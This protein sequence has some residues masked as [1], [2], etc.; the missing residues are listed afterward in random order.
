M[1]YLLTGSFILVFFI[2]T[3]AQ[4]V[5]TAKV[6]G[7][8]TDSVTHKPLGLVSVSV[9]NM[10]THSAVKSTVTSDKGTFILSVPVNTS[11]GYQLQV[12]HVGYDTKMITIDI[13]KPMLDLGTVLLNASAGQ[14]K[15][16]TVTASRPIVKQEIDRLTYDVQADPQAKGQTAMDMLRRVPL[17]TVDGDDN[18]ELQGSGS[19]RIFINGK[20]SA[21]VTNNPKD[22]LRAMP[23]SNIQRIEVIT[24]PPA[25]YDAEGLAGII[26]IIT[27]KKTA[28]GYNGTLSVRESLPFGPGL[29]FSGSAKQNKL[30]ISLFGGA[31]LRPH[32]TT[33]Q[34]NDRKTYGATPDELSQSAQSTGNG[35]FFYTGT[36]I[37][38][39]FDSLHLLSGYV[40]YAAGNS[41]Q[42]YNRS[43]SYYLVNNGAVLQSYQLLNNGGS[44]FRNLDLGLNYQIGFKHLKDELLTTSY[45][46]SYSLNGQFSDITAMQRFKFDQPDNNQ[47]DD[48]GYKEHTFQLDYVHP[49]KKL[50]IEAGAKAILRDNYS[51][52][53][54]EVY[55]SPAAGYVNDPTRSNNFNYKQDIY[56]IYNSYLLR[57]TKF[58][59]QAGVRAEFTQ[60]NANFTSTAT[61]LDMHYTNIIPTLSILRTF[62][63]NNSLT[64]GITNRLMRPGIYQL[65]PFVDRTNPQLIS[66]GNPNLHPVV[67]HL[68]E[69]SYNKVGKSSLNIRLSYMYTNNSIESVTKVIADTLSET[70]YDNVGQSKIARININ[71][72]FPLTPKWS[73][74]FNTGVFYVWIHGT[75]NG[76]FYSN[77]GPRTNTFV[78]TSYKLNSMW[79]FGVSAGYNRRYIT[80][81]GSSNDYY[82]TTFSTT[83]TLKK[84]T[85]NF[86]L[87]NPFMRYYAFTQYSDT[88]DFYQSNTS[89]G[90]YRNFTIGA[91]YK[92]GKLNSAIKKNKRGINNDDIQSSSN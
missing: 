62:K 68:F 22:V 84:F 86:N 87:N 21:L 91:S 4:G 66:T 52:S 79:Q 29:N 15:D 25:K 44:V 80:L 31:S 64:F 69:L 11:A 14:L 7:V 88:P 65:N 20:P 45:R 19:Y 85:F 76:Q 34:E 36:E 58:T 75:Y 57:L 48:A 8:V 81:Q 83:C 82:Y 30:G 1:K 37:S 43:S 32:I 50:N 12:S 39:E 73:I 72:N 49:S 89:H 47:H 92:F 77:Q 13:S 9:Q 23:A 51:Y 35:R 53:N 28:D 2:A 67:S 60:V 42:D 33:L 90:I 40:N 78:N 24:T 18:I 59:M 54:G 17:I 27:V 38:D 63:N 55:V 74:N 61:T 46:Y 56:S 10:S 71:G 5:T 6:N 70:T 3:K 41:D 16:V 26:N